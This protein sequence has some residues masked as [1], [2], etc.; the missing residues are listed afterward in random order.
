MKVLVNLYLFDHVDPV[1]TGFRVFLAIPESIKDQN[2]SLLRKSQECEANTAG[3]THSLPACE[4]SLE[5]ENETSQTEPIQL[6]IL[7]L[8]FLVS[9][10]EAEKRLVLRFV[11]FNSVFFR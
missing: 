10:S 11:L 4:S 8:D 7:C 9:S 2:K 6:T 5:R 3:G 1:F